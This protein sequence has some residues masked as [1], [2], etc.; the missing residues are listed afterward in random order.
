M[1]V[2]VKEHEGYK[3]VTIYENADKWLLM[4]NDIDGVCRH[5]TCFGPV[6]FVVYEDGFTYTLKNAS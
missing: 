4:M 2:V 3:R 6:S 1:S 5:L